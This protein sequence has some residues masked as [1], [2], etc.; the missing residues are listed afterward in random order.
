MKERERKNAAND[1]R[2][3]YGQWIQQTERKGTAQRGVA[4][5]EVGTC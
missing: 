3:D 1:A 5:L 2:R 4:S